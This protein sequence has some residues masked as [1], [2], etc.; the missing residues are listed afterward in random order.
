MRVAIIDLGTNKVYLMVADIIG[1]HYNVIKKKKIFFDHKKSFLDLKNESISTV[2]EK[3][4]IKSFKTLKK[5]IDD[6]HVEKI[7]AKATSML[8]TAVNQKNIVAAVQQTTGIVI[9]IISGDQEAA[10]I[11]QGV[12]LHKN[13]VLS[14][15]EEKVLIVDIGGG[16]VEF[17]I[18]NQAQIFWQASYEIGVKRLKHTFHQKDPMPGSAVQAMHQYLEKLLHSFLQAVQ[19][20][21]PTRMIGTS[22]TFAHLLKIYQSNFLA[23]DNHD[24]SVIPW[25]FFRK[26]YDMFINK[27]KKQR[28]KVM[29]VCDYRVE[30]VVVACILIDFFFQKLKVQSIENANGAFRWGILQQMMQ[31][32]SL[33][34][35]V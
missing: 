7:Q 32:H 16:S 35:K 33:P 5:I 4:I 2:M 13:V 19:K 25:Q 24:F 9:D 12:L 6:Y 28:L 21:H 18:A 8:R 1:N 15:K 29:G 26:I 17:I 23:Q 31:E 30:T 34:K 22:G 11:Y 27:D 3:K 14:K 10:Y 20:Y